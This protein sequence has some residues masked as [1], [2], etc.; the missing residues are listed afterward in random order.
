MITINPYLTF[1]GNCEDAFHFYRS[2]FG[3]DFTHISRFKDMP[4][5]S[6]SPLPE[7]EKEN[8][9]HIALPINPKCTIMGCD[10]SETFGRATVQG[11]NFSISVNTDSIDE[12]NRIYY[13]LSEDGKIKMPLEKTF[14]GA[15]FGMFTDKFGIHWMVNCETEESDE[16]N[17]LNGKEGI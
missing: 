10:S 12:I 1:N 14:W 13:E 15:Y 8:I 4:K 2:V 9:L 11:N 16:L 17:K 6:N 7:A 5:D 3:G